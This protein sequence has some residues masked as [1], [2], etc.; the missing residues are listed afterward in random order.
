[1]EEKVKQIVRILDSAKAFN[2]KVLRLTGLT[3]L[4]DYFIIASG[5]SSTQVKALSDKV[6][7]KLAEEGIRPRRVEGLQ[8]A[9]WVLMDYGD[10]ILHLFQKETRDFYG[11]EHLW[12]DAPALD[13][14]P[15]LEKP[16]EKQAEQQD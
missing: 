6:E 8:S 7:E 14:A 9:S 10:I 16:E 15:M 1:M 3:T 12:A 5:G 4:T 13:I 2:L 11:I